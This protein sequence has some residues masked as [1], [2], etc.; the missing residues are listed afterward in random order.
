MPQHEGVTYHVSSA[1]LRLVQGDITE[2]DTD[3]IVNAANPSLMGGGGVDGAIHRKGGSKILEECKRIRETEYPNGLPTG[4]AVITSGGNLKAK[5]VIHT[6]GPVWSGGSK[7]EPEL[8]AEAYRNSLK[9]AVS[10]GLKSIA[11]PSI[12]TGAYG[13]PVEKACRIALSTVKDFLEK[14]DKLKEVVFVLYTKHDFE[15][16]KRAAEEILSKVT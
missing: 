14:E 12:S 6:V 1:W 9:L 10:R 4:K 13:Y 3:A 7:G 15:V 8:L 5:Y 2:M 11:F 16:Y